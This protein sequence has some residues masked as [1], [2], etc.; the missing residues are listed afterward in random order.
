LPHAICNNCGYY[1]GKEV[2]NVAIKTAKKEK[3]R[4]EAAKA[5]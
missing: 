4:K 5:K 1:K 2:V 3:K